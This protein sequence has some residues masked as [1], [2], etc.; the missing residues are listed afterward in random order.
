MESYLAKRRKP[1]KKKTQKKK[2]TKVSKDEKEFK[3][4]VND[5]YSGKKSFF[6]KILDFIAGPPDEEPVTQAEEEKKEL[7][8]DEKELEEFEEK[9]EK[10]SVLDIIKSWF[11][12]DDEEPEE[13][14]EEVVEETPEVPDEIR[15]VLKIQNK[16]LLR[17]PKRIIKDFKK[18]KDYE[19]YKDTLGKYNLIKVKEK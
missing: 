19:V 13:M 14:T 4:E 7:E 9:K 17:L 1:D 11:A 10:K 8:E 18:S 12:F 5:Y 6:D 3:K 2:P 15:K 16:W